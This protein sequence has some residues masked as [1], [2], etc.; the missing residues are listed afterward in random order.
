[1]EFGTK[2]VNYVIK[3][4]AVDHLERLMSLPGY[5]YGGRHTTSLKTTIGVLMDL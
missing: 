4:K 5:F 2:K 1:M 3:K